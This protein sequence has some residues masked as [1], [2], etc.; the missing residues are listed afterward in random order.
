MKL[1]TRNYDEKELVKRRHPL[2]TNGLVCFLAVLIVLS[3]ASSAWSFRFMFAPWAENPGSNFGGSIAEV[4]DVD[5]NG[6]ADFAVGAQY[7]DNRKGRV[8]LYLSAPSGVYSEPVIFTNDEPGTF[9]GKDISGGGDVN[10]DGYDDFLTTSE[11]IRAVHLFL[12][13][14]ETSGITPVFIPSP[15]NERSTSV[16]LVGDVN[17]DG[18]DDFVVGALWDD[19]AW[20]YYGGDPVDLIPDVTL[21]GSG[22]F[23]ITASA[24]GD[25][26]QDGYADFAIGAPSF[27]ANGIVP[28]AVFL[29]LGGSDPSAV[30]AFTVLGQQH[31][32]NFGRPLGLG[33]DFNG[34]G[35]RDLVVAAPS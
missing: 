24:A 8:Y 18:Y 1:M 13:A 28:G 30:A 3:T 25:F 34:D 20:L 17:S 26:N 7:S 29:Y 12:G 10:N 27:P 31:Q 21:S 23:G 11:N 16:A 5:G 22:T 9:L 32:E 15:N 2:V 33:G 19:V 6:L 35:V 4:G 14:A